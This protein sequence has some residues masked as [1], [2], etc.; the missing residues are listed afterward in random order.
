[1]DLWEVIE[2]ARENKGSVPDIAAYLE[3]P[4][5]LVQAAVTHS[6]GYPD[7]IDAEI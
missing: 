1:L 7:K 4:V 6:G 3:I 2:T 5:R